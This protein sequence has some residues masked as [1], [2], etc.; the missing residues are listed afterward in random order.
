MASEHNSLEP[1]L[2]EMTPAT[3]SS[4]VVPNPPP[5]TPFVPPSRTNWDLVRILSKMDKNKP[6]RAKPKH[7]NRKSA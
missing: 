1:A 6:K 5:S 7:R 2:Y 3:I 4:G